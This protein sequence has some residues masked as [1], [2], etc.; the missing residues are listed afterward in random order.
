MATTIKQIL[1]KIVIEGVV[2]DLI[3]K[4]DGE[5]VTV[6]INGTNK[7]LSAALA[8]II[9]SVSAL[10][11]TNEVTE[12]VN[13][14]ISNL[15]SGA[16]ETADT[17]KELADL[18]DEN[19]DAMD[20]L[21]SAIGGKVDKEKGKGLSANDFTDELKAV[22]EALP[23]ITSDDVAAWNA[24]ASVTVATQEANGLMSSAD[25]KRLD[26]IRGVFVAESGAIPENLEDGTLIVELVTENN[27]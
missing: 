27:E 21:N 13:T 5:N 17:L 9:A 6:N 12:Q 25:K 15:V 18:I 10:P 16:P 3:T 1:S 2:T 20:L 23:A 4:S 22:L 24:K 19:K 26:E 8:D 7:L 14:A 11:T